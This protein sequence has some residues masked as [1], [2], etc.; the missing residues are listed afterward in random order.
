MAAVDDLMTVL[1]TSDVGDR[2]KSEV[3]YIFHSL[4]PQIVGV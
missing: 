4:R 1:T 2:E 3:L